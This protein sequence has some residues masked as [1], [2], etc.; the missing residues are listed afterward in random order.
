LYE[1]K[2]TLPSI[3][4]I[5]STTANRVSRWGLECEAPD[6]NLTGEEF[7]LFL[8]KKLSPGS[9]ILHPCGELKSK[10]MQKILLKNNINVDPIIVYRTQ[11]INGADKRRFISFLWNTSIDLVVFTSPSAFR[12]FYTIWI[13]INGKKH[14]RIAAL[15]STTTRSIEMRGWHVDV[16][17]PHPSMDALAQAITHYFKRI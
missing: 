2:E 17:P 4:G 15:G 11:S 9:T 13:Q 6:K 7:A 16:S 3:Y 10:I 12:E 1:K 8:T 5:G 14:P